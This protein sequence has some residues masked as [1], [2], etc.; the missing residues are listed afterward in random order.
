[1]RISSVCETA[2]GSLVALASGFLDLAVAT[3]TGLL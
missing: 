2:A 1:M 3:R